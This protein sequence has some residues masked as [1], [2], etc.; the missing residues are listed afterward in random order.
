MRAVQTGQFE[1][2]SAF[3]DGEF[4]P[5]SEA[6]ISMFD[7]GFTR[8]DVTYDVATTWQGAFFRL[9]AHM[10]RF[11]ASLQKMRLAIPYSRAELRE[12][13]H[14]VVRAGGLQDAYVAMVCT[15]GVPPRGAR[16]PRLAQNRFY[17]YALPYVWIA[18]REKQLAGLDLHISERQRIP[19]TSVD[20]TVKNYHWMDLVQSLYD[21]YDQGRDTSCVVDAAG[22]IT[23]G[24]GFNVFMVKNGVVHTADSGVLEGISRRTAIELCERLQIPVHIAPVP[25]AALRAADE[26]FLTSSG[27]GIL[28]IAR[29]D[30]VALPDFPGPVAGRL[31]DAYWAIH[32]EAQYRDPVA[33]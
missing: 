3:V 9:D 21:A 7:W 23:E 29:L 22:N 20:P 25:S 11:F 33:Y 32:E 31:Y 15:R 17:A 27:G 13:L 19:A 1:G 14:G 6:K 2:G 10:D 16:D 12:I 26:V 24:P 4:V 5:L 30:G 8:S 28:P 18:S